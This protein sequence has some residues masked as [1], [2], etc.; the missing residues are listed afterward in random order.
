MSSLFGKGL[1]K[2]EEARP[3]FLLRLHAKIEPLAMQKAEFHALLSDQKFKDELQQ[4][5]HE[6]KRSI[7][8]YLKVTT[9]VDEIISRPDSLDIDF[10]LFPQNA[11]SDDLSSQIEQNVAN[12]NRSFENILHA[13]LSKVKGATIEVSSTAVPQPS[14]ASDKSTGSL[15]RYW[16][17]VLLVASFAY[18]AWLF[19]Q[20][21]PSSSN[22]SGIKSPGSQRSAHDP[23]GRKDDRLQWGERSACPIYEAVSLDDGTELL[24]P[25][26]CV[27]G[28]RN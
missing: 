4:A 12:I 5:A 1:F 2:K 22:T 17:A 21:P 25:L 11:A 18:G 13:T 6:T 27:H 7:G 8:K 15:G 3:S 28:D 26:E 9:K 23:Q 19:G 16:Q 24:I 20:A 14:P 10:S